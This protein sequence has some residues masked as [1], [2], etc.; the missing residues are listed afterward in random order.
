MGTLNAFYV[1]AATD[2]AAITATIRAKFPKAEIDADTHFCGVTMPDDAF[3][4]PESVLMDLSSRLKTDVVWLSFQ[5]VVDAFQF[6]HWRAGEHLRSLVYGCFAEERTW[7]RAEGTPE[8]WEREVFFGQK[9]LERALEY[10]E[11]DDEKREMQRIW[12][13]AEIQAG[14][15]EPSLDGRECARAVAQHFHF[16]G[17]GL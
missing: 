14:R 7:E 13:D 3:E 6:H 2:T 5:S 16:P 11:S 1:R 12:H 4:T 8:P 17:W 15:T 9:E 10:L